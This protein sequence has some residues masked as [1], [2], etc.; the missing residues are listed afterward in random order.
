MMNT[1]AVMTVG[2]EQTKVHSVASGLVE[3]GEMSFAHS[4]GERV[5]F[6]VDAQMKSSSGDALNGI[7]GW[8]GSEHLKNAD[9]LPSASVGTKANAVAN[10]EVIE[11]DENKDAAMTA[12][13]GLGKSSF[14][15]GQPQTSSEQLPK[16]R[17]ELLQNIRGEIVA[18]AG[19]SQEKSREATATKKNEE[20]PVRELEVEAIETIPSVSK[21][22]L[23]AATTSECVPQESTTVADRSPQP[24]AGVQQA[25]Q[26]ET[27]LARKN[28]DAAS[29]KKGVKTQ[30]SEVGAKAATTT[31]VIESAK[32]VGDVSIMTQLPGVVPPITQGGAQS[33][34]QRNTVDVIAANVPGV[35]GTTAGKLAAG[36]ST[37]GRDNT[38]RK[39]MLQSGKEEVEEMGQGVTPTGDTTAATE[40]DVAIAKSASATPTAEK[41]AE[42]K[43]FGAIGAAALVHA[44]AGSES[45][46]PGSAAGVVSGQAPTEVKSGDGRAH[47]ATLQAELGEQD[48]SGTVAA[49]AGMS[50]RTLLATP[51]ALEVGLANGTQGWL[52]I[53][54]ELT[55]GGVVNASLS[56][57]TPAGQ[58]MLHRELPAL[59]A[60]LQEERVAV[61]TVVVPA[62]AAAGT[63]SR[64][65]GGM[66]EEGSGQAEQGGRQGGGDDRQRL[67]YGVSDR[68]DEIPTHMS[69][70]GFDEDGLLSAG[71]Y[72]GGGSWLNVRA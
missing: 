47:S 23:P 13:D 35:L 40:F 71:T 63:E 1:A 34:E 65:A 6:A 59:T 53:R 16:V 11:P 18:Q 2:E 72:E 48:G 29:I 36:A 67:I 8:K 64:F 12:A 62:T 52:K 25:V 24:R 31:T 57:A 22:E 46:P 19:V 42:E 30:E 39:A 49:E 68:A 55:D 45:V 7:R 26:N 10:R 56:S 27:V 61:N 21:G 32:A 44:G 51:T 28:M 58:E 60:Y 5:G 3:S 38:S 20:Q 17:G 70:S 33:D 54:A 69:L 43:E 50:H 66:N 37:A 41:N 4:F 9:V 14:G 15:R